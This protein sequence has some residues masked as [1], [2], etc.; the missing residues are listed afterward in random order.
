MQGFVTGVK[1]FIMAWSF[2]DS[3]WYAID[4]TD[5]D[6]TNFNDN[7]NSSSA[8][9]N[10]FLKARG[11]ILTALNDQGVFVDDKCQILAVD[12]D[13]AAKNKKFNIGGLPRKNM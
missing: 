2:N 3:H 13:K 10:D 12:F 1:K 9:L 8:Q 11:D 6:K 5:P 4:L 7:E